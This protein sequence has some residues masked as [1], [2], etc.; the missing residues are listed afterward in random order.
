MTLF[1][2]T[3]LVTAGVVVGLTVGVLLIPVA[4]VLLMLP[5]GLGSKALTDRAARKKAMREAGVR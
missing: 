3:L 2:H 4:V 5:V 1:L